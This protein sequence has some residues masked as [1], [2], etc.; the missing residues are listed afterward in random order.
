[1]KKA[2][3]VLVAL[4]FVVGTLPVFAGGGPE[5]EKEIVLQWPTQEMARTTPIV[6]K[7]P[8]L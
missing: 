6:P 4:L 8:C 1:M 3:L 7:I 2:L 5:A